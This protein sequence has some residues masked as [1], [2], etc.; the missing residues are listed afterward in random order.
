L[1]S[2]HWNR[3][4]PKKSGRA[5]KEGCNHFVI[6]NELRGELKQELSYKWVWNEMREQEREAQIRDAKLETCE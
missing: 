1:F 5:E 6:Q 4:R 2:Y 3:K